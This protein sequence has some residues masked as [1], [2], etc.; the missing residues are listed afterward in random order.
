MWLALYKPGADVQF[1]G[2][3]HKVN[4]VHISRK[5]LFVMLREKDVVVPAEK[6]S[7]ALT[8]VFLP[9]NAN[10]EPRTLQLPPL[11]TGTRPVQ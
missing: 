3:P 5:G 4:Y 7:V 6:V 11:P 2:E 9:R 8:R 1:K 10:H